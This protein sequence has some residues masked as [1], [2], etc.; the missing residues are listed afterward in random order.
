VFW[1]LLR[2]AENFINSIFDSNIFL[3]S[4]AD[5]DI[6]LG[7]PQH[8]RHS[9]RGQFNIFPS[10]SRLFLSWKG[11]SIAKLDETMAG[12]APL[13]PPLPSLGYYLNYWIHSISTS[14]PY[15]L[16]TYYSVS[17]NLLDIAPPIRWLNQRFVF[18]RIKGNYPNMSD[19]NT[20]RKN[21]CWSAD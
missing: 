11:K 16:V 13:D 4:L 3:H 2:L 20:Q 8:P 9:A 7:G 19:A 5:P 21:L 12:L 6:R 17:Y 18:V 1:H 10:V 15:I 14:R